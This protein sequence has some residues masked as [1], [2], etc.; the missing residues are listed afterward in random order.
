[1]QGGKSAGQ[2]M[3]RAAAATAAAAQQTDAAD[4]EVQ[5]QGPAF[6]PIAAFT[7]PDDCLERAVQLHTGPSAAPP[8]P[9]DGFARLARLSARFRKAVNGGM[10]KGHVSNMQQH[11]SQQRIQCQQPSKALELLKVSPWAHELTCSVN[12][13]AAISKPRQLIRRSCGGS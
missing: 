6:H 3:H 1:M 7:K 2:G 4:K 9:Q 8:Q 5:V 12:T 10:E 13:T 11:P